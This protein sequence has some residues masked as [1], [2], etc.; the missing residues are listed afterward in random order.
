MP[1]PILLVLTLFVAAPSAAQTV[2]PIEDTIH[3]VIS[4]GREAVVWDYAS[5]NSST[6]A[7]N[8]PPQVV[9]HSQPQHGTVT[10]RPGMSTIRLVREGKSKA[11]L[12][13]TIPGTVVA[14]TPSPTFRGTDGFDYTITSVNGVYHDT[15]VLDV[16]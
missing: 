3:R 8:P 2:T 5:W 15:V 16:R 7:P 4:A 6:C 11:C 14:Y 13:V 10:I 12:G 1:R 9:L